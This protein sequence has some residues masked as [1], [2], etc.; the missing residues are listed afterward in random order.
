M[1]GFSTGGDFAVNG[2]CWSF[3]GHRTGR[4][5]FIFI[6]FDL[7]RVA[8][9]ANACSQ[10]RGPIG[11]VATGLH[12]SHSNAGSFTHGARPGIKPGSSWM[13]ISFVSAA[14]RQELRTGRC[15]LKTLNTRLRNVYFTDLKCLLI[16]FSGTW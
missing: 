3:M 8:S 10:A 13:L 1:R 9:V 16:S 4:L 5:F 14:P 15:D 11:A 7:F 2:F 6:V 12:H